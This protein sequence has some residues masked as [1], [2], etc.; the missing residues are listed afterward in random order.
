M[1]CIARERFQLVELAQV[2]V[3]RCEHFQVVRRQLLDSSLL[4]N[5]SIVADCKT[6]DESEAV[7]CFRGA[8]LP[9]KSSAYFFVL[10]ARFL[11]TFFGLRLGLTIVDWFLTKLTKGVGVNL[12]FE[13]KPLRDIRSRIDKSWSCLSLRMR[14]MFRFGMT[15]LS[16]CT[17]SKKFSQKLHV[18]RQLLCNTPL[19]R[20]HL[21]RRQREQLPTRK[22]CY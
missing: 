10:L 12:K 20:F 5:R 14:C 16:F 13:S 11:R 15:L 6:K 3:G 9:I 21:D 7:R 2:E 22:K 17:F 1:S 4:F 8:N 19:Q 18:H